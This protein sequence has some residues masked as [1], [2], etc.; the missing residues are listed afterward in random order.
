M[1][2]LERVGVHHTG[3]APFSYRF[4]IQ[5]DH[6]GVASVVSASGTSFPSFE[7][8]QYGGP[9]GIARVYNYSHGKYGTTYRDLSKGPGVL[10]LRP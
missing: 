10:P 8:Y 3:D 9:A 6:A 1:Y 5:E 2:G 4:V 7:I